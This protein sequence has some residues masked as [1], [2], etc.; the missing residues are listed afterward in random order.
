LESP[1]RVKIGQATKPRPARLT[2]QKDSSLRT[3]AGCHDR[4]QSAGTT[5]VTPLQRSRFSKHF[6]VVFDATGNLGLVSKAEG[7][8]HSNY[9]LESPL[10]PV[11]KQP[12]PQASQKHSP[13][14]CFPRF[15]TD[16][17]LCVGMGHTQ[18]DAILP[19]DLNDRLKLNPKCEV[20]QLAQCHPRTPRQASGQRGATPSDRLL[21]APQPVR[22]RACVEIS[23][24]P[25]SASTQ[26][27]RDQP[28][29]PSRSVVTEVLPR[30]LLQLSVGLL[31]G[32]VRPAPSH[33]AFQVEQEPLVQG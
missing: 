11:L 21:T 31:L 25:L 12:L 24:R 23:C 6:G 14:K 7:T 15:E 4:K 30:E 17:K 32:K 20:F 8:N 3:G 1:L 9:R 33:F 5:A 2:T 28:T 13:V 27:L 26:A 29:P 19:I 18:R 10:S 16:H 22:L